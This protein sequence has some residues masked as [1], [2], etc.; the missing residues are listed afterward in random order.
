[1]SPVL[2]AVTKCVLLQARSSSSM[3]QIANYLFLNTFTLCL[4]ACCN[5]L[6]LEQVKSRSAAA[7]MFRY[8]WVYLK[9]LHRDALSLLLMPNEC[10]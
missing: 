8:Q 10:G 5:S 1:M 6:V 3:G 7:L 9:M 2:V 4:G